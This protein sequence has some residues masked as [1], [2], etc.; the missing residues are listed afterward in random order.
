MSILLITSDAPL[1]SSSIFNPQIIAGTKATFVNMEYLPPIS[2]LCSNN[3]QLFSFAIV[4]RGESVNYVMIKVFEK[5]FW[6]LFTSIAF[7]Y[8]QENCDS[9][10][11]VEPDFEITI[12]PVK[13]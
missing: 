12:K 4:K 7:W 9:V 13:S 6:T 8:K 3:K 1:K 11:G 2:L 10:S 5:N